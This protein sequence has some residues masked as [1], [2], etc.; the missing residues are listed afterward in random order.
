[1]L[2]NKL[3]GGLLKLGLG[4]AYPRNE[5][6]ASGADHASCFHTLEHSVSELRT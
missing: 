3:S 1:V 5:F 2:I 4:A 6:A